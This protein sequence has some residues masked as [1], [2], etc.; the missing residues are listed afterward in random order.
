M[1]EPTQLDQL[2]ETISTYETRPWCCTIPFRGHYC[3]SFESVPSPGSEDYKYEDLCTLCDVS[4]KNYIYRFDPK[5]N[6]VSSSS[7]NWNDESN[8][9]SR[10]KLLHDIAAVCALSPN[11]ACVMRSNGGKGNSV[12]VCCSRCR[13]SSG[14]SR[15]TATGEYK[16]NM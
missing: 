12:K 11:K 6:P 14:K 4:K 3:F 8:E 13:F 5:D 10:K 2:Y 1:V 15:G 7:T 9:K 16:N